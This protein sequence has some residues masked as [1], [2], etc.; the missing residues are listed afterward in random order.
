MNRHLIII[1]M[2][3]SNLCYSQLLINEIVSSN[4]NGYTDNFEEDNDWVEIYNA[5]DSSINMGGM[6]FTDNLING[7]LFQIP[8][9]QPHETTIGAG[10]YLIFWF[11]K[12][13][14]QGPLHVDCKLNSAGE[15]VGLYSSDSTIIDSITFLE[16]RTNVSYGR[17]PN[18]NN[19][20]F[21]FSEP[22]PNQENTTLAFEGIINETAEFS[23]GGGF[24]NN[25]IK[26][27][28][29]N[30]IEGGIHYTTNGSIPDINSNILLDS[31]EITSTTIIRS[32]IFKSGFIE[33]KT[34]THTYFLN[35]SFETRDLPV[36]SISSNPGYFWDQDTGIYVQDFK[37]KWEYPI[38][39]ELFEKDGSL[40]FNQMATIQIVGD[41][42]WQ[43]PQ[44]MLS[45]SLK[46]NINYPL[47]SNFNR[48]EYNSFNLRAS[49]SDWSSTLFRDGL[50]Q[51]LSF[52]DMDVDIQGFKPSIV[53]IN[54]AYMGIHNIRQKLNDNYMSE[55]YHIES[56]YLD[57][58][59]NHGEVVEGD[60][61]SY[62]ELF[63]HFENAD[64]RNTYQ[65]ESIS[66]LID[67]DNFIDYLIIEIYVANSSWGHNI[68]LWKSKEFNNTKWRW[69]LTDLD[70]GFN[71]K[72]IDKDYIEFVSGDDNISGDNPYFATL[73][74]RKLFENQEFQQLFCSKLSDYLYITLH[75]KSVQDNIILFK[76]KI[77]NEI[78]YHVDRWGNS[79]SSYG[80]GIPSVSDWESQINK[81]MDFA[82]ERDEYVRNHLVNRFALN[83][84]VNLEIHVSEEGS[85]KILMNKLIIPD[86][87]WDGLYLQNIPVTFQAIPNKGYKFLYWK[88]SNLK[89]STNN[90]F[91][92]TLISDRIIEARFGS[93]T[94]SRE[95]L[96]INEV[97]YS[98]SISC[99]T[100]DWIEVYNPN[101]C[102]IDISNWVISD[103]DSEDQ[104]I[105]PNNTILDKKG[106]IVICNNILDFGSVFPDIKAIGNTAFA[107]EKNGDIIKL[108]DNL[109]S[110]VDSISFKPNEEWPDLTINQESTIELISYLD[111]N[112]YGDNWNTSYNVCGTPGLNNSTITTHLEE[113]PHQAIN[114]GASFDNIS[115]DNYIYNPLNTNQTMIW[116]VLGDDN[117]EITI[118]NNVAYISCQLGWKGSENIVFTATNDLLG[119]TLNDSVRFSVGTIITDSIVCNYRLIKSESPYILKNTINV[120]SECN[121]TV[122]AGVEI[123]IN[124][125]I[126]LLINGQIELNGTNEEPIYISPHNQSWGGIL[127]DNCN[128]ESIFNHVV[129]NGSKFGN[130]SARINATI[131]AYHSEVRIINSKFTNNIRSIYGY[132][133][134]LYID[135]CIFYKSSGEKINLQYSNSI[136]ENCTL[137]YTFGDNDAIDYDGVINGVIRK[138]ILYGGEDDGID[139]G[140]INSNSCRNAH[141]EG[142]IIYDFVD[143]GISIGEGSQDIN[144]TYNTITT[145][146]MGIA[147][148]DSSTALIDHNTLYNNTYGISCYEKN[149]GDG[150]GIASINNTIFSNSI[151]SAIYEDNTSETDVNYSLSDMILLDGNQNIMDNPM[152]ISKISNDFR[153]NEQSPCIN[154]GDP[155]S[156]LDNDGSIT[157]IGAF[158]YQNLLDAFIYPNPVINDMT[159]YLID[160][161]N[162]I[163]NI[164]IY[165]ISGIL[166]KQFTSINKN[167]I[168]INLSDIEISGIYILYIYDDK[169]N[170]IGKVFSYQKL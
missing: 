49:G 85:G 26:I 112:S 91:S 64:F 27:F 60:D 19:N 138:N 97:N 161:L 140:R 137:H 78:A 160:H 99:K 8:D 50:A 135:N 37:P 68:A 83:E 103:Q 29:N 125:N 6:Y 53:F 58:I 113:I 46:K 20:W 10:A 62:Q 100:G 40:A 9:N 157:D 5:S 120:P 1:L 82:Q 75:T 63:Y 130:D 115:L 132:Y 73:F 86:E 133:G 24:F 150:G 109:G 38:N 87:N 71:T 67:I 43:L 3:T 164:E 34:K 4:S 89:D 65:Y 128:E 7:N 2:I 92:D 57:L 124:D 31:L 80:D 110:L 101:D 96:V 45:I 145:S 148:K 155:L 154:S 162:R 139:I 107:L 77:E 12:D 61:I 165:N 76:E 117:L 149:Y 28:I 118:E 111:N 143:K 42:S 144:I 127:L 152:F 102:A 108:L 136:V 170:K 15:Q 122:E 147:V 11:D 41:L 159:I 13:P 52:N 114:Y 153:L 70:R 35:E 81:M 33:S 23:I 48:R 126:D 44:K 14:E 98:N 54:G 16:Q 55:K 59:E 134:S 36:F 69:F 116:S 151:I 166:I 93:D 95:D 90:I 169:N 74:L 17:N 72:N 129:F 141:L 158:G 84:P 39:I 131:S 142:N 146:R 168:S 106:Y 104:F 94:M 22:T 119:I 167:K 121:I 25:S 88:G 66:Q 18:Q 47:I 51:N 56:E 21:F 79:S 123:Y 156:P 32:K 30:Q 163:K 105:I